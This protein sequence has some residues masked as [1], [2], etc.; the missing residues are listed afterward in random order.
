MNTPA[1]LTGPTSALGRRS[2]CAAGSS[3]ATSWK[4]WT[5]LLLMGLLLIAVSTLLPAIR[6]YQ[7]LQF[8]DLNHIQYEFSDQ[9]E[10]ITD[11][12][13]DR[14]KGV[15][16]VQTIRIEGAA[17]DETLIHVGRFPETSNLIWRQ[18]GRTT[19]IS[20]RGIAALQQ[21]SELE[22]VRLLFV[23]L[24]D[25]ML[26]RWFA[27]TPRLRFVSIEGKDVGHRTLEA[28]CR[29]PTLQVLR[30]SQ[31]TSDDAPFA[32]LEASENLRELHLSGTGAGDWAATWISQS[33]QLTELNL[34]S[35]TI[36]DEGLR[37][38]ATLPRLESLM[39][40]MCPNLSDAGVAHLEKLMHV[41]T[42]GLPSKAITQES[43]DILR[44]MPMLTEVYVSG[45]IT[46]FQF[47]RQMIEH[48]DYCDH[49]TDGDFH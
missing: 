49:L 8:F 36:T 13:G 3:W 43:I 23:E 44:R 47:R 5:A 10:W 29:I 30:F 42:L 7:A 16:E 41:H 32:G 14:A 19:S 4:L 25:E 6:R 38:I 26:G 21:L 40:T 37:E 39:L 48:W 18:L 2:A 1:E 15:R 45:N 17:T 35:N 33:H 11:V 27:E 20:D 9:N 12:F 34:S 31:C 22:D 28:L 46:N 24:N